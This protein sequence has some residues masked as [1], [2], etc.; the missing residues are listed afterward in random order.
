MSTTT[1]RLQK[2]DIVHSTE[3][4]EEA[5]NRFYD[6]MY[7]DRAAFLKRNWRWLYRIDEFPDLEPPLVALLDDQ[8]IAHVAQ[9]PVYLRKGDQVRLG[10]WGVDGGVLNRYRGSGIGWQLM[11]TWSRRYSV[12]MGFCTEALFRILL[13][14]GWSPRTTTHYLHL[15][16]RPQRHPKFQK[17]GRAVLAKLG[18]PIWNLWERLIIT[19]RTGNWPPLR[20]I[21]VSAD[22]L[23]RWSLL[24]HPREFQEPLHVSRSPEFMSWRVLHCP[25]RDQYQILE[26]DG[27]D[28]AA[29]ARIYQMGAFRRARIISIAGRVDESSAIDRFLG[30][31]AN[32]AMRQDVDI[33]SMVSSDPAIV[34]W[35]GRWFPAKSRL[36][37]AY[38]CNDREGEEMLRGTDHIWEL[39]DYDLDFLIGVQRY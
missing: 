18:G 34:E 22:R 28:V 13:K 36:R 16:F 12:G 19:L 29:L 38:I 33:L 2:I 24:H 8:V 21:P 6:Q 30:S 15:P 3:V 14:Q 23:E 25:F 9:I 20:R 35:A 17:G 5:L 37:F 4:S 32:W 27:A 11:E 7:P 1:E 26:M 10:A 31:L 39:I